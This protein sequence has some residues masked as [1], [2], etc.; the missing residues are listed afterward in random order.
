MYNNKL[1]LYIIYFSYLILCSKQQHNR[2]GTRKSCA[3]QLGNECISIEQCPFF[4]DILARSS[5]PRPREVIKIIRKHH[6]GFDWDMPKVCCFISRNKHEETDTL[7]NISGQDVSNH[8]NLGL[9][10][11]S[12][13]GPI[14]DKFRIINGN[15]AVPFEFPWMALLV[16][17][18]D[19]GFDY[20]CSGT[21][22]SETYV[23]TAAHCVL[24]LSV[25]W[26]RLGEYDVKTFSDCN[27]SRNICTPPVQ[28]VSIERIIAHEDYAEPSYK[29]DI[30]L[31]R[32]ARQV[33]LTHLPHIKPICLPVK[34]SF[35]VNLDKKLAV[36]SGWGITEDGFKSTKLLKVSVPVIP[37]DDCQQIYGNRM[38]IR[39]DQICARVVKGRD[40]CAG[41]SGGPLMLPISKDHTA[42]YV[43]YG[44]V[45]YG[46][47]L[48]GIDG[49]PAVYTRVTHFM[50]WILD[51]MEPF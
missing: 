23:V 38:E 11:L 19:G 48:C 29:N 31:L 14:Y 26:V 37:N 46:P 5:I 16:Y 32:L 22:I 6:C 24:T 1:I 28:D 30:A 3:P 17:R 9:L 2:F 39:Q 4:V 13:C 47:N 42:R 40:S 21:L 8:R 15:K 10:P 7:T 36:I 27:K 18:V 35:D 34:D 25:V 20:R 43:Q 50:K 33:N 49:Q 45:S 51:N 12:D 41:D 44:I